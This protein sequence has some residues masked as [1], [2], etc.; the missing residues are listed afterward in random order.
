MTNRRGT[1]RR[2]PLRARDDG[3]TAILV[4]LT[5]SLVLMGVGAM[6]IDLGN[7]FARRQAARST[8][9]LAAIAGAR[10]LPSPTDAADAVTDYL[11][12]NPVSG[13]NLT[14]S[15]QSSAWATDA[16]LGNGEVQFFRGDID[17]NGRYSTSGP[18]ERTVNATHPAVALRVVSPPATVQFGLAAALGA[19]SVVVQPA[20]NAELATPIGPRAVLPFFLLTTDQSRFCI[21]IDNPGGPAPPPVQG[22]GATPP[23]NPAYS[24]SLANQTDPVNGLADVQS[25]DQLVAT[26]TGTAFPTGTVGGGSTRRTQVFVNGVQ[27]AQADYTVAPGGTSVTFTAPTPAGQIPLGQQVPVWIQ[28]NP[29]GPGN[30]ARTDTVPITYGT[31]CDAAA[32]KRGH[33]DEAW[34]DA[35]SF[36]F[37]DAVRDGIT[38]AATNDLPTL[39]DAELWP[40]TASGTTATNATECR[41]LT[42]T[43]Q[44]CPASPSG[45]VYDPDDP[46]NTPDVNCLRLVSSDEFED[47]EDGFID[48]GNARLK[49]DCVGGATTY[50]ITPNYH[51]ENGVDGSA[52]LTQSAPW[53]NQN[54]S[55]AEWTQATTDLLNGDPNS[56]GKPVFTDLI[57][58]CPRFGILPVVNAAVP[59]PNSSSAATLPITGFR[60]I[61]IEDTM[62]DHGF[63]WSGS[64]LLGFTGYAF[65]RTFLPAA[66]RRPEPP[67]GYMGPDL[68]TA[69]TPVLDVTDPAI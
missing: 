8:A 4:A 46:A 45:I 27:I 12:A 19:S 34:P 40:C 64:D 20:A 10:E 53:V 50:E 28:V 61:W 43:P 51:G 37:E 48:Q 39:H 33:V 69:V 25:G 55:N 32:S 58:D 62:G 31:L 54:L 5:T 22:P 68:V 30:T 13:W 56:V 29:L 52:L 3:A 42:G 2:L 15:P 6:T 65:D 9:D 14:C 36:D 23:L 57:Y 11:C 66:P 35:G 7:A 59:V 38:P 63:V 41:D 47:I 16:D 18:D 21:R 67:V 24:F 1:A 49:A 60:Y 17:G 26:A 44:A